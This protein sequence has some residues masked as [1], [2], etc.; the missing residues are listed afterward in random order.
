[1]YIHVNS[2]EKKKII[3][4]KKEINLEKNYS[5][6]SDQRDPLSVA[7]HMRMLE[8]SPFRTS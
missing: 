6:K 1:M 2:S 3:D 4:E 5:K 8:D 7:V